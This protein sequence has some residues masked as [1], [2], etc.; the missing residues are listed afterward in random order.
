MIGVI[1]DGYPEAM[2]RPEERLRTAGLRV[3][4][5][6]VAVLDVLDDARRTHEHLLVAEVAA[7]VRG[8][9]GKV[10][11][12]GVYDCLEALVGI[13]AVRRLDL[14]GSGSR[15]ESRVGDNHHHVTCR[16]CG[17]LADVDCVIGSAPCLTPAETHGFVLDEAEVVFWGWCAA[18]APAAEHGTDADSTALAPR[19][20]TANTA[21]TAQTESTGRTT[22]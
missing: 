4:R 3:T 18:C 21:S 22:R 9:I 13:G 17:V 19:E 7:R 12:Q 8:R 11:T 10:S 2:T 6:R 20:D 15:Y 16:G 1:P 5:P 14:P